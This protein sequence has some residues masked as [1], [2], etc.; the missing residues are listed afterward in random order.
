MNPGR[1]LL[2][3]VSSCALLCGLTGTASATSIDGRI[4]VDPAI[5]PAA[6]AAA[7][8]A[9]HRPGGDAASTW[10]ARDFRQAE[11]ADLPAPDP[12]GK[13]LPEF[14]LPAPQARISDS[15]IIDPAAAPYRLH[16]KIFFRI[17]ADEYSCSGTVVDSKNR[18][19]I[20]TAGHCVFDLETRNWVQDLVFLPGYKNG[21][22]PLGVFNG[23]K[24]VTTNGWK[25]SGSQSY[26]IAAVALTQ[27]IQDSF[28]A[29][30]IHFGADPRNRS[31][32]IYGY[33]SA[34]EGLYDG[35]RLIRCDSAFAGVDPG[36]QVPQ[37]IG[38]TPCDMMQG[39]SGGGWI[40]NGNYLASV[41]SYGYCDE[42]PRLCGI[43]FGPQ[44]LSGAVSVYSDPEAGVGGSAN[45]TVRVLKAPPRKVR[46]RKV[47]FRLGANG[48]TPMHFKVKLDRQDWVSTASRVVIRKLSL[49]KHTL[50]IRSEDQIGH[51]SP[52]TIKRVF[53]VLPKKKK[54][55]K[56]R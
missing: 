16:G 14:D 19:V 32:T 41:V 39:S 22:A 30:K 34:P 8:P 25:D 50:R 43:T 20:F 55:K 56:R 45:P 7:Q 49:G 51:L 29:R 10:T 6:V 40:I 54:K 11:P 42:I 1:A 47:V 12:A 38:A 37:P 13:D 24:M 46:K 21:Q 36:M 52:R 53:K 4:D 18:N 35:E 31:Y 28:G 3:L 17:G 23:G 15:E 2:F 33:P 26:D 5:T 27:P 44:L 48:S 9:S